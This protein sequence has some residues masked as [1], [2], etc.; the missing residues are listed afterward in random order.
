MKVIVKDEISD[1]DK[2]HAAIIFLTAHPEYIEN[3]W[4]TLKED[5]GGCL[6]QF[7]SEDGSSDSMYGCL[8]QVKNEEREAETDA[9]TE[10]IRA[11]ARIPWDFRSITPNNLHVFAEWQR[12]LD[13]EL[14]RT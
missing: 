6:F 12:R 7:A 13:K 1:F 4:T 2:Y 9:L 8:T 10:A 5:I 14:N 11:D 3:A